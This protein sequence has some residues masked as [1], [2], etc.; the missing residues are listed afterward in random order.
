MKRLLKS[1]LVGLL[2]LGAIVATQTGMMWY[3]SGSGRVARPADLIVVFPGDAPRV[4]TGVALAA[5]GVAFNLLIAGGGPDGMVKHANFPPQ[6][7]LLDAGQGCRDTLGDALG[8]RQRIRENGFTRI[9]LVTSDYHMLRSWVLLKLLLVGTGVEIQRVAV[10]SAETTPKPG[11]P[12][13]G[14]SEMVKL[15]ANLGELGFYTATGKRL[16]HWPPKEKFRRLL[17]L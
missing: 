2:A 3:C 15:W 5:K 12:N 4:E 11:R 10:P 8:T 17:N 7:R 6:V 9:L 16:D 13:R 1:L 14:I